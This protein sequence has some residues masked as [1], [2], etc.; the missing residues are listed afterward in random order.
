MQPYIV[1]FVF[2]IVTQ[3]TYGIVCIRGS[4]RIV[5]KIDY[6]LYIVYSIILC[7]MLGT[8]LETVGTDT[9]TYV[10][11]FHDSRF[12]YHEMPTDWGFE[13]LGRFFHIFNGSTEWFIL[14]TSLIAM[15]GIIFLVNK[16]SSHKSTSLFLF[17]LTGTTFIMFQ[18]YF[19]MIRQACSLSFYIIALSLFFDRENRTKIKLLYSVILFVFAVLIHGSTLFALPFVLC[20]CF[21][22]ITNKKIWYILIWLFYVLSVLNIFYVNDI[23]DFIFSFLEKNKYEGYADI[24][25]G[26]IEKRNSIF[27]MLLLPYSMLTTALVFLCKKEDLRKWWLQL[28]LMGAVITNLFS[29]NLMWGRLVLPLIVFSIIAIP[30]VMEKK[31][32]IIRVPFYFVTIAYFLYKNINVLSESYVRGYMGHINTNV[33]YES[34]LLNLFGL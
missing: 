1:L 5:N 12:Y 10:D 24:A 25:F 9:V 14:W 27:N 29:D 13:Q 26:E 7:L 16:Y 2:L 31:R 30:N 18:L 17:V 33:P 21:F 23:L 4:I 22:P 11:F 28:A 3:L 6:L 20:A 32:K 19:S 8:R 15:S 34:W